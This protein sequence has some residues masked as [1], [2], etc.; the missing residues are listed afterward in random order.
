[1]QQAITND[2]LKAL[3]NLTSTEQELVLDTVNLFAQN[4]LHPGLKLHRL[5]KLKN[6]GFWSIYVNKDI[7]II[8]YK[9]SSGPWILA[10]VGHHDDAYRWAETHRAEIHPRNGVLQIFRTVEVTQVEPRI[11]QPLI[12]HHSEEYLL[13]LGVPPSYIKPLLLVE[14]EER[15]LELISGLPQDVQERLLDLAAG[16]PV[17]PPPKVATTEEWLRHP[18]ARQHFYLIESLDEL[19]RALNY[20]WEQWM[21]FLH[22]A[23]REA[24]E[25][26]FQGPAR[27]VGPAGTGKT[28]VALHRT[29]QLAR[30]YPGTSILLTS[31]NRYLASRLKAA[32]RLLLGE[33]PPNLTV[34]NIHGLARR[35]YEEHI[36]HIQLAT[37]KDYASHLQ[38][39]A[40][41]LGHE[42]LFLLSE[43]SFADEWG[44]YTWEAYRDFPRTGRGVPLTARER[45][46][47]F[48][49]FQEVWAALE[50]KGS[51]TFNGLLHRLRDKAEAGALPRFRAVVVDEAQD[52]GPAE[53]MLVRAIVEETP[54][55]LFFALDPGQRI[56]KGPLSWQA[57][58][59]EVRGR[60]IRL[61]VNYRTT[62]EIATIAEKVLPPSLEGEVRE[63]LSLLRGP[64]P[65]IRQFPTQK[66]CEEGLLTWVRWLLERGTQPEEIGVLVRIWHLADAL[67]DA[68]RKAH[69]PVT[70]LS[71]KEVLEGGVRLGTVHS[72]KG[73]EFRAVAV[74][75][76]NKGFFP[77][78][79]QLRKAP[80]VKD[81]EETLE[82]EE[83]LLY[84][85]FSRA[86]ERLWVGYWDE[87]SPFLPMG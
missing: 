63:V 43:F 9:D 67:E 68:F 77:L 73:L 87:P 33:L 75:G 56:Y 49:V 50:A 74:F 24:V 41:Q 39:A 12:G 35:W 66:A 76:A 78:E 53:L 40:R 79:A 37:E 5:D 58:G 21:L 22:P 34:E 26:V 6:K 60:S 46:K 80:S 65:E 83:H 85:A 14:D 59:L 10:Y 86:R 4:P 25:R 17:I 8:L 51:L 15:F 82:K 84:V 42:P 23:Q 72:A 36:G 20:P 69:I 71:D 62:R 54:D 29:A 7:R 13:D 27:V 52:L 64:E 38:D 18:L 45:M 30:R 1:M 31:F 55:N 28:V 57:L 81:R 19:R 2:F 32:L 70:R 44:L 3:A 47:L 11:V 16:K 61:R 48:G